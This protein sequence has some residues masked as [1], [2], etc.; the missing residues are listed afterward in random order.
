[1]K[2]L[3]W[4]MFP[5]SLF[6][7]WI[8][9]VR[10]SQFDSGRR[11]T[12]SFDRFVISV[13]NLSVGGTG[14]TPMIEYLIRMLKDDFKL[15]TLSR[16][17]GRSTSG[18]RLAS[19]QDDAKTIGD[20][21]M[22]FYQKFGKDVLVTVGE[23]RILAIPSL[24]LDHPEAEVFLLDDAYQHRKAGRDINI[25]LTSYG[26]P[27]FDDH[28]L[29]MGWLR[30]RRSGANR[31]DCII[32]TKCPELTD[33]DR[34]G[35]ENNIME[36]S[37]E[38]PVYF[39]RITYMDPEPVFKKEKLSP[40]TE[41]ILLTGLADPKKLL[42]HVSESYQVK[43]H[44]AF[45]DHHNFSESDLDKVLKEVNDL[46]G[47]MSLL[48][49]EKDMVRLLKFRDHPLFQ[50]VV[51]FYIPIQFELDK[52]EEFESWVRKRIEESKILN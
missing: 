18:F 24:L 51:P 14:K 16:G 9:S 26:E 50:K 25:L 29:P 39:S 2:P 21:P 22:Q 13:G 17:Y 38:V 8:T 47:S 4:L 31:A 15:A 12:T 34:T 37:G 5:F 52:G 20:E 32:V 44:L 23:E 30:E 1:M 35:I 7:G 36:Y 3:R 46:G 27:F 40:K 49:S 41:V 43:K 11:P 33:S 48:T 42:E 45:K 10:N 28:V 19:D 6:Y